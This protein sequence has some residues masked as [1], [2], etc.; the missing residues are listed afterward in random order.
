MADELSENT[1]PAPSSTTLVGGLFGAM[2][3]AIASGG[4]ALVVSCCAGPALFIA[5]GIGASSAA[6]FE[7]LAPYRFVFSIL[8]VGM[9]GF[10]FWTLYLRKKPA[11]NA[12][13]SPKSLKASR[14]IFWLTVALVGALLIVSPALDSVML[15]K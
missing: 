4:A 3:S 2:I 10:T 14:L 11:C 5:L 12:D 7:H 15:G 8:S 1:R 6:L 13:C 9:L